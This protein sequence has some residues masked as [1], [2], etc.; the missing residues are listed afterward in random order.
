MI[1]KHGN[2][3]VMVSV[4]VLTKCLSFECEE[5]YANDKNN[6]HHHKWVHTMMGHARMR[7]ALEQWNE[8]VSGKINCTLKMTRTL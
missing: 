1:L 2:Q 8:Q 4:G 6:S 5:R 7:D 3:S